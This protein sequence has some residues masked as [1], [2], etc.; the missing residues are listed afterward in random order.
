[1]SDKQLLTTKD[2]WQQNSKRFEPEYAHSTPFDGWFKKYLSFD[3]AKTCLEIGCVPGRY[4]AYVC[5]TYGYQASGIDYIDSLDMVRDTLL[6]NEISEARLYKEDLFA[7]QPEH[8]FDV[9]LSIGFV[10][11]FT[12]PASVMQKHADLLAPG[13]LAFVTVPNFRNGQY[14]LHWLLDRENLQRHSTQLM[15][16]RRLKAALEAAGLMVLES[17]YVGTLGFW[18]QNKHLP[19]WKRYLLLAP[20]EKLGQIETP[21][22]S[23]NL[24][25]PIFSPCM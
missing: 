2:C 15:S 19:Q 14:I 10:E 24:P 6:A 1:M 11:H 7:W 25:N 23:L 3:P 20:L 13:G 9:I 22:G 8:N 4:L 17:S 12:A 5:R 18:Y 21:R 16:P